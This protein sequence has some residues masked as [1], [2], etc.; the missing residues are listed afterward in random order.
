M[1]MENVKRT[2]LNREREKKNKIQ[3]FNFQVKFE[4]MVSQHMVSIQHKI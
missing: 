2:R 4:G 3:N 1:S